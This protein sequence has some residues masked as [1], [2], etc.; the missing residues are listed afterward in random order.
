ML[1]DTGF[2]WELFAIAQFTDESL[3]AILT[4]DDIHPW[5]I[6]SFHIFGFFNGI[7]VLKWL[8]HGMLSHMPTQ[9]NET[10]KQF[11]AI[12]AF[13]RFDMEFFVLN[14]I[15]LWTEPLITT[16]WTF[17]PFHLVRAGIFPINLIIFDCPI[18]IIMANIDIFNGWKSNQ[19]KYN[20]YIVSWE[21]KI[22]K[23][24]IWKRGPKHT[25]LFIH[26]V[27]QSRQW[28]NKDN[29]FLGCGYFV[30]DNWFS[31]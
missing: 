31:F 21:L 12:E 27:C 23:K 26:F 20:K 18:I 17:K 30:V 9:I 13:K 6:F 5:M 11:F 19:N 29:N 3:N 7:W 10:L 16:N 22:R 8:W 2:L 4:N 24:E 1:I 28:F 15:C 25:I 14:Q